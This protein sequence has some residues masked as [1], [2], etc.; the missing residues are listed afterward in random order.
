[1]P[2]VTFHHSIIEVNAGIDIL[3][4]ILRYYKK[5]A[6]YVKTGCIRSSTTPIVVMVCV[7]VCI[8]EVS[9]W[10]LLIVVSN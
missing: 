10:G 5:I 6:G 3:L 4:Y 9:I 2:K 1:M 7:Y 8:T